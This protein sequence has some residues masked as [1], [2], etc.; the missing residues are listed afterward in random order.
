MELL[1]AD[2]GKLVVGV[3]VLLLATERDVFF[4]EELLDYEKLDWWR[5]CFR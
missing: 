4:I 5:I 1:C 2:L 3:E